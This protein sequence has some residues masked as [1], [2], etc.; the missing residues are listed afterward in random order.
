MHEP[1]F[2]GYAALFDKTDRGGDIIRKGAFERTLRAN[3]RLALLWQH[4]P[5]AV[6]GNIVYAREDRRG[7]RVIGGL[8]LTLPYAGEA[9]RMLRAAAVIG[10]SFGYRVR[11]SRG[12]RPRQLLDVDL[13]EISLV[14]T[15]MQ[16]RAQ[17]H[18]LA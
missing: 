1:R 11:S 12:S 7:L 4:R 9:L 5:E 15:P 14:T 10:L 3:V 2:A 8:D 13:V 6:I 18:A 17:V 16:P